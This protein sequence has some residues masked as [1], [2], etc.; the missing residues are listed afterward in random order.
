MAELVACKIA[1]GRIQVRTELQPGQE[2]GYAPD[3]ELRL[4]G[5]KL[6][7][8]AAGHSVLLGKGVP[9]YPQF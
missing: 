2:T 5:N 6:R 7:S 3:T 9:K 8:P 1:Q 4:S